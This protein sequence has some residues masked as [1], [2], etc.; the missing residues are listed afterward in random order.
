M[1]LKIA[2]VEGDAVFFYRLGDKPNEAEVFEQVKEMYNAFH[3]Q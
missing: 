1:G 3:T 2:E